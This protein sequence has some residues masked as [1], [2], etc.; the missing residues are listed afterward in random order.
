M[1]QNKPLRHGSIRTLTDTWIYINTESII[2]F[3]NPQI[4]WIYISF[5][6]TKGENKQNNKHTISI[7][8]FDIDII[9]LQSRALL[10]FLDTLQLGY[11]SCLPWLIVACNT[12]QTQVTTINRMSSFNRT[13]TCVTASSMSYVMWLNLVHLIASFTKCDIASCY[14]LQQ[15]PCNF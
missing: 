4:Q 10:W 13:N 11:E 15:V 5:P 2:K 14:L 7:F 9:I 8:I 3:L 6:W 12:K 1:D